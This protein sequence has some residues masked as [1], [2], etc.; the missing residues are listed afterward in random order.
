VDVRAL[1]SHVLDSDVLTWTRQ[2]PRVCSEEALLITPAALHA[3]ISALN[4]FQ[5]AFE[6]RLTPTDH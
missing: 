3:G 6:G 1:L 5:I 4:A 2:D